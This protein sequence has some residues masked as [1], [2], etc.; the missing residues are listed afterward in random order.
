MPKKKRTPA[1]DPFYKKQ[2]NAKTMTQPLAIFCTE[3]FEKL[4]PYF[5][6]LQV[7]DISSRTIND[8]VKRA[9]DENDKR[10]MRLFCDKL[11]IKCLEYMTY[12]GS[13]PL[14]FLRDKSQRLLLR[15]K[16]QRLL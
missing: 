4:K 1:E 11:N 3:E 10:L 15:D 13:P 16:S 14:G 9:K 6:G 12:N 7:K 2:I 5:N 8:F